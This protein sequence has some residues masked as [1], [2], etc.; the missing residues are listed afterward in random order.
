MLQGQLLQNDFLDNGVRALQALVDGVLGDVLLFA[1]LFFTRRS[2]RRRAP[3]GRRKDN[4]AYLDS[5]MPWSESVPT[6]IRLR[7]EAAA[8]AAP[9]VKRCGEGVRSDREKG[10]MLEAWT[11]A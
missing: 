7:P 1:V 8:E 9:P 11:R 10:A 2:W 6:E 3:A 4:P 5:L